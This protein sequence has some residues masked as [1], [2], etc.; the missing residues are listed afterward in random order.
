M[1]S[2]GGVPIVNAQLAIDVLEV[3]ANREFG[4]GSQFE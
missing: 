3:E 4:S 1:R 2:H